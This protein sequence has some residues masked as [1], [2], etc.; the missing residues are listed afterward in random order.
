[1]TKSIPETRIAIETLV[2]DFELHMEIYNHA[3]AKGQVQETE[4]IAQDW[5]KH[6]GGRDVHGV[7]KFIRDCIYRR[8]AEALRD[9]QFVNPDNL[10][11]ENKLP[12]FKFIN[13]DDDAV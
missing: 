1:M 12:G 13:K 10:P 11:K 4:R 7:A 9:R 2:P 8:V 6:N 5:I 3:Y